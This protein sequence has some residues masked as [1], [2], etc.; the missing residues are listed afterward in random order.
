MKMLSTLLLSADINLT[1]LF[2]VPIH[3]QALLQDAINP[4]SHHH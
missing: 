1:L 3:K 2:L 4:Q